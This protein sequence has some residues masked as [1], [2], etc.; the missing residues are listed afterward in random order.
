MRDAKRRSQSTEP[1]TQLHRRLLSLCFSISLILSLSTSCAT[2]YAEEIVTTDASRSSAIPPGAEP[3]AIA[4]SLPTRDPD[5]EVAGD[6]IGEAI[7]HLRARQ[8]EAALHALNQ[9]E[10]AM[11]RA[12]HARPGEDQTHIALRTALKDLEIAERAVQH[13]APN[14]SSQLVALNKTID[15][16]NTQKQ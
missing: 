16:L 10:I 7:T 4:P 12:L 11:N 8:R 1:V 9:A 2:R 14:A 15:N 3:I 5:I 6:R 13:S